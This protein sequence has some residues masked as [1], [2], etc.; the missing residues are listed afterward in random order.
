MTGPRVRTQS[1]PRNR[2]LFMIQTE[3]FGLWGDQTMAGEYWLDDEAW[4]AIDALLPKVY[5]GARRKDDRRIISGII[6]V[7]RSGCRWQDCPAVYGPHTTVYNRFNRWSGRGRWLAIFESLVQ[8][9]PNDVR[10]IDSTSIKVQRA[11]A[12]GK[13]GPKRKRSAGHVAAERQR[14][15]RSQT[16]RD[17]CFAFC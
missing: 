11:A 1:A 15:M 9:V 4:A 6:H 16:A 12:G 7:L 3:R 17:D 8:I 2:W 10:S 13:G 5:P 14:S